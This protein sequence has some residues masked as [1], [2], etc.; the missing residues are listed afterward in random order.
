MIEIC[1]YVLSDVPYKI[2][3]TEIKYSKNKQT[4]M[5]FYNGDNVK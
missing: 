3:F 2:E 4:T 5:L 1:E